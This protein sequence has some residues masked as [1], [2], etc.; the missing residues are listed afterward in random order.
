MPTDSGGSAAY[1][2][3]PVIGVKSAGWITG[4]ETGALAAGARDAGRANAKPTGQYHCA[5]VVADICCPEPLKEDRLGAA[6]VSQAFPRLF[7]DRSSRDFRLG[8]R[9]PR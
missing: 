7:S 6:A 2:D 1:T 5:E 9:I 8:G 3:A 4:C